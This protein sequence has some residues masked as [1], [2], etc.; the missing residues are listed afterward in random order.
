MGTIIALGMIFGIAAVM[1]MIAFKVIK[2]K[3]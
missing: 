1:V 3:D 2:S